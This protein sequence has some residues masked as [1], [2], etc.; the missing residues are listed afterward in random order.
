MTKSTVNNNIISHIVNP[1]YIVDNKLRMWERDQFKI[2][3]LITA[4]RVIKISGSVTLT[5]TVGHGVY[6]LILT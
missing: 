2:Q 3:L 4:K 1:I 6:N 5:R